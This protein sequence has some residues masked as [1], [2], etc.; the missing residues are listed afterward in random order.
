MPMEDIK[1]SPR[2]CS[3]IEYSRTYSK[4]D[5]CISIH[6]IHLLLGSMKL[7]IDLC[8][9]IAERYINEILNSKDFIDLQKIRNSCKKYLKIKTQNSKF[10]NISLLSNEILLNAKIISEQYEEHGQIYI[11]DS[12]ILQALFNTE[13][14]LTKKYLSMIDNEMILLKL[15]SPRDMIVDLN[16]EFFIPS[17]EGVVTRKVTQ[18]DKEIVREFVLTNF[19]ERWAK[20]VEYGLNI[21]DIPIYIALIDNNIV[22]FAG[23][24]ISKQRK[25][26]FGPLGVLKCYRDRKI[27]QALLN[28]CLRNIKKLG[29]KTCIIGNA[30]S[31]EFYQKA[32]GATVITNS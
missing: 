28:S 32:C 21:D 18:D 29:F 2:A 10:V 15:A 22:G 14:K 25:G 13:D 31:I 17:I 23:Y 1:F 20:T 5:E 16:K 12:H 26:Y 9:K 6:P 30:S 27:G 7:N 4:E 3:L 8:P 24:N 11:N 19:Y